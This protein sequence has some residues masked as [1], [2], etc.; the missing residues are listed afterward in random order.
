MLRNP[1]YEEE[2]YDNI[3]NDD[4]NSITFSICCFST[5]KK[6][7]PIKASNDISMKKYM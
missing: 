7:V 1:G 2:N 4:E 5:K 6:V 3:I